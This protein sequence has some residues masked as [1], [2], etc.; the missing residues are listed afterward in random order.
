VIGL[1]STLAPP[2]PSRLAKPIRG[3]GIVP[4]AGG[5][6]K[7]PKKSLPRPSS[8]ATPSVPSTVAVPGF[9]CAPPLLSSFSQ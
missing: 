3:G 1:V 4:G 7:S 2:L 5:S 9:N 6:W 8:T